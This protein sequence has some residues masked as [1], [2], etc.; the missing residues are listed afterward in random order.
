MQSVYQCSGIQS[1]KVRSYEAVAMY[2]RFGEISKDMTFPSCPDKS[3]SGAQFGCDQI[4]QQ[5]Q[6]DILEFVNIVTE[7]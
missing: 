6:P 5:K 3:F 4:C 2:L 1:L 7:I